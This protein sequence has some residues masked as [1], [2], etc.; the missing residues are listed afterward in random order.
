MIQICGFI[1][2]VFGCIWAARAWGAIA[3]IGLGLL[4]G[5]LVLLGAIGAV[6]TIIGTLV[7]VSFAQKRIFQRVADG[8]MESDP[9]DPLG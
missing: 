2:L 5:L 3:C 6:V 7:V 1:A 8:E 4:G 9:A